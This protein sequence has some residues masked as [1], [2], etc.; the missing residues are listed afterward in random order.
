MASLGDRLFVG[1]QR[2]L[3]ARWLGR[4]VY[5]VS[6]SRVPWLR[7]ALVRGFIRLYDIDLEE[8]EDP[9]PAAYEHL[10][11]FFT[12]AL[13]PG[14]RPLDPDPDVLLCPADGT[15]EEIGVLDADR[16]IQAKRFRYPVAGLLAERPETVSQFTGGGFATVYLAPHNYHRVH[17]PAAGRIVSMTH[18]PGRRWAVNRRTART[19][20]GLFAANERLVCHCEGAAGAFV[21]VLVGALNVSSIST[22]WA[23]ELPT[24]ESPR[25]WHYAPDDPSVRLARGDLLGQFNLGSTV[26]L[27][28]PPGTVRWGAALQPGQMVR[29][30]QRLGELRLPRG[31]GAS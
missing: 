19:I 26:I 8:L 2:L 22:A 17:M 5:R 13:R 31:P 30:G 15:L 4:L 3:P 27:L 28:T 21:V 24:P 20:P 25:R 12:R 16:L 29:V 18:V 11:A 23:G 1:L 10:N 14:A 6:R 9:R 7:D